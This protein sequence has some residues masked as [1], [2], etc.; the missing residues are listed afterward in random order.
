MILQN[1][2]QFRNE[3][4]NY[5]FVEKI[6]LQKKIDFL[7]CYIGEAENDEEYMKLFKIISKWSTGAIDSICSC[8]NIIDDFNEC[9]ENM[10]LFDKFDNPT[11]A[12]D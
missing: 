4:K 12:K 7:I 10:G 9:T 11:F 3:V 2:T 1:L 5:M 8:Q 6:P